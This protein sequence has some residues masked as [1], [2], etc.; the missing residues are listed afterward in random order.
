MGSWFTN[1]HIRKNDRIG[2]ESLREYLCALMIE[3]QFEWTVS[4]EDA[5]GVLAFL[6][7]PNGKWISLYSDLLTF[8]DPEEFANFARPLSEKFST[9]VLGMAC[10]DSDYAYMNLINIEQQLDA[11]AAAGSA[12][13]L[14]I[15]RRTGITPWKSKVTDFDVFKKTVQTKYVCA[16]EMLFEAAPLLE[17]PQIRCAADYEHLQELGLEPSAVK[18]YFKHPQS[19]R[20]EEP[21]QFRWQTYSM[22]PCEENRFTVLSAC[23]YGGKSKGFSVYFLGSYVEKDEITFEK[24]ELI[25]ENNGRFSGTPLPCE[26]I[27]LQDGRW[28]YRY[29]AKNYPIPQKVDENLPHRQYY[30]SLNKRRIAVRFIPKG[31]PRKM[32]D[33]I[34]VFVPDQNRQGQCWWNVW[35][36]HYE[37][38]EEF[39]EE[40][41]KRYEKI[42]IDFKPLR[43]EDFD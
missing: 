8:E 7:D 23:N 13:G 16:E 20:N 40:Y 30:E 15:K 3:R 43:R 27:Q 39:I 19:Q 25:Q 22:M 11:W 35:M 26:K 37:S 18:L 10:F 24:V 17:L 9:D 12:A 34:A 33:V 28:A 31:D 5:D 14:G 32:L 36:M 38:K 41:N 4:E 2:V 42:P 1:A 29:H 21:V 6:D